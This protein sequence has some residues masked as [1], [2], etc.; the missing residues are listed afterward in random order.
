MS[1]TDMVAA[2]LGSWAVEDEQD[3]G[4]G[5]RLMRVRRTAEGRWERDDLGGVAFVPLIGAGGW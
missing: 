4:D 3:L 1:S 5:Q 2:D